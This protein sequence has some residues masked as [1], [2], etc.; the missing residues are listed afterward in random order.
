MLHVIIV[1]LGLSQFLLAESSSSPAPC[2]P[3]DAGC[4][5]VES[6]GRSLLQSKMQKA[7]KAASVVDVNMLERD[8]T[9][10]GTVAGA[11]LVVH[12]GTPA[13]HGEVQDWLIMQDKPCSEKD[14]QRFEASL[15]G[16]AIELWHGHG[17]TGLCALTI[18]ATLEDLETAIQNAGGNWASTHTSVETDS[19]IYLD[20]EVEQSSASKAT[21][22]NL[23]RI[24]DR[25]G[26][27]GSYGVTPPGGSGVSVFVVDSGILDTHQEFEGRAQRWADP[28]NRAKFGLRYGLCRNTQD[29][30]C[31]LDDHGHGTHC[32]GTV[33][34]KTVGVAPKATVLGVKVMQPQGTGMA[35]A[36]IEGLDLVKANFQKP[37][38]VSMSLG[39]KGKSIVGK[40]A[41][42]E[43]VN[44][45]VSVVVAAGNSRDGQGP[46][47]ACTRSYGFIT[48]AITVGSSDQQDQRS[49]FSNFGSCVDIFAP[50]TAITSA[51]HQ[52]NDLYMRSSG[53]SMAA[54]AVAGAV[55][56][57]L[58]QDNTLTPA[59]VARNLELL[60][61]PG[62]L[63]NLKGGPNRL[64]FV[65]GPTPAPGHGPAPDE[66]CLTSAA[67]LRSATGMKAITTLSAAD[68]VSVFEVASVG[69]DNRI[70]A[71]DLLGVARGKVAGWASYD[72]NATLSVME[73]TYGPGGTLQVTKGHY[74]MIKDKD[75]G[76]VLKQAQQ[77]SVGD[78]LA[79]VPAEGQGGVSWREILNSRVVT[80]TGVYMPLVMSDA[81]P[82]DVLVLA[83][84]LLV[85]IYAQY[86]GLRPSQ[87]H[88][89]FAA[90]EMHW[91]ELLSQHPCL[92]QVPKHHTA[93]IA[94]EM[95]RDFSKEHAGQLLKEELNPNL[96][97]CYVANKAT[98]QKACPEMTEMKA[99]DCDQK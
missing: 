33:A 55:A 54:P 10:V 60:A 63:S 6:S 99:A 22:W 35:S 78:Y 15:G 24:D 86:G 1:F 42:E 20:E 46:W 48:A 38:L 89:V 80:A 53:T 44:N 85:P 94:V 17:D 98:F 73:F 87:A 76:V 4:N 72:P 3:G 21:P 36:V 51:S 62:R 32:A 43:L 93:S 52:G 61:T 13:V 23:D 29:P 5:A 91:Q 65:P 31:G 16:D 11:N 49:F 25:D 41:V 19:E 57:M 84:G 47:D 26:L 34:G 18:T 95:L 79:A 66:E 8:G 90:W 83:D 75:D 50:G 7:G 68:P 67:V 82:G 45:G 40:Y 12:A 28:V 58:S 30:T 59:N 2:E 9:F 81:G 97:L 69:K 70:S 74:L 92:D 39:A 71:Q 96:L 77:I 88:Q 37:S 64:L 27:D 14:I 56:R